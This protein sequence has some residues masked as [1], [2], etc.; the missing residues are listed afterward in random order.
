MRLF[1]V[2]AVEK[3]PS[4]LTHF[5]NW[6]AG[7]L[8]AAEGRKVGIQHCQAGQESAVYAGDGL[9][10]RGKYFLGRNARATNLS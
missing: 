6:T 7:L 3:G 1:R 8:N 4:S 2:G 5:S 10:G 9:H